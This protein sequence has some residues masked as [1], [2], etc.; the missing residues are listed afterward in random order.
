MLQTRPSFQTKHKKR[1]D[2]QTLISLLRTPCFPYQSLLPPRFWEWFTFLLKT[3]P[4]IGSVHITFWSKICLHYSSLKAHINFTHY[5][6]HIP[7][8]CWVCSVTQ[9]C[10]TLC[11]PWTQ[12]TRPP[13]PSPSP[14]VCPSSCSLH[15]WCHPVIS[16]SDALFSF[17]P[18]SYPASGTFTMSQ[19]FTSG[20]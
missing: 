12:H 7:N 4:S 13:C 9:S 15:Q 8:L 5:S 1:H 18:Q 20:D 16:S 10:L 6:Q 3:N 2:F 17:C 14:E 19:L 11:N